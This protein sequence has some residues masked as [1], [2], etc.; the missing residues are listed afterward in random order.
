M[1]SSS[2]FDMYPQALEQ[3]WEMH[4]GKG[5]HKYNQYKWQWQCY[6]C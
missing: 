1:N 3:E 2:L 5:E 4:D 6:W